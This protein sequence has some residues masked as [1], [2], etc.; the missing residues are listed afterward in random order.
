MPTPS[1]QK[2]CVI[3]R[4]VDDTDKELHAIKLEV[5]PSKL[6]TPLQTYVERF[7]RHY[8][9][10]C[11]PEDRVDPAALAAAD[12]EG[13]LD[14][15]VPVGN[16]VDAQRTLRVVLRKAVVAEAAP[17]EDATA[18]DEAIASLNFEPSATFTGSKPGK[19][20]KRGYLCLLY[21]SP[22]PRDA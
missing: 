17:A 14:A 6:A 1:P 5:A 13:E 12:A 3:L 10:R 19:A 18:G 7:A 20:F 22:S 15:A 8:N 9:R 11:A 16:L 2:A 21:T 4:Y